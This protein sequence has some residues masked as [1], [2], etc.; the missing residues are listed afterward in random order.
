MRLIFGICELIYNH[1]N[2]LRFLCESVSSFSSPH[3]GLH[4]FN[5][6]VWLSV[7][8]CV[9]SL[10]LCLVV[11]YV[12]SHSA[13]S[14]LPLQHLACKMALELLTQEFGISIDRL[15]VTY[16]GGNADAGLEPDLECK[17]I[18]IDLG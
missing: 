17:Q 15:Y 16:F 13:S 7:V 3:F 12:L 2:N 14:H 10:T 9:I 6:G 5:P 4:L 1:S 8:L 11:S 18:W